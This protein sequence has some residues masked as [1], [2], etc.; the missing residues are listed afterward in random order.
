MPRCDP[1]SNHVTPPA[2]IL[3]AYPPTL[4]VP[5]SKARAKHLLLPAQGASSAPA[6][7][8][9][10]SSSDDPPGSSSVIG[11]AVAP[12][13][14]PL[15]VGEPSNPFTSFD[16]IGGTRVL[17][18]AAEWSKMMYMQHALQT[19][20]LPGVPTPRIL[21]S[22]LAGYPSPQVALTQ[23]RGPDIRRAVVVEATTIGG[24]VETLDLFPGVTITGVLRGLRSIV[25]P[26][27][28]E[29]Q[30]RSGVLLC[31]VN[32]ALVDPYVALPADADV[33]H[34]MIAIPAGSILQPSEQHPATRPSVMH[35]TVL[36]GMLLCGTVALAQMPRLF[37]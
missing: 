14:H 29:E 34:F 11:E 26:A 24:A 19:A 12:A 37:H 3:F 32:R 27:A 20:N 31:L 15:L 25:Y 10:A 23:D 4:T 8:P 22:E 35:L 30:I 36:L 16:E 21:L 1:R 6:V 7:Q 9:A 28:L 33:I 2:S 18:G 5:R 13:D 17:T